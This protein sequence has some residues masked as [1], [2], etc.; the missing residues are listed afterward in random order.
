[1]MK[2]PVGSFVKGSISLMQEYN[3]I[4]VFLISIFIIVINAIV[5]ANYFDNRKNDNL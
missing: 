1:M 3:P 4:I 2:L 5:F